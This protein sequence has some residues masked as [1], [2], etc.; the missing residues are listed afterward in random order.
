MVPGFADVTF[1]LMR[2][3]SAAAGG[4][5]VNNHCATDQARM[6]HCILNEAMQLSYL[7]TFSIRGVY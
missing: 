3:G 6:H 7:L 5:L 1:P 4:S 2:R